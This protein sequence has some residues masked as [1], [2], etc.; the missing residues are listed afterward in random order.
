MNTRVRLPDGSTDT[1]QM[2][3][4]GSAMVGTGNRIRWFPLT[5]LT[6]VES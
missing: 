3:A 6:A 1:V 4:A 2:I 5:D